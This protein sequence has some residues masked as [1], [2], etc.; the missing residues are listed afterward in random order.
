MVKCTTQSEQVRAF[1]ALGMIRQSYRKMKIICSD[2][3]KLYRLI[4]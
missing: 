2:V 4:E 3:R 1:I